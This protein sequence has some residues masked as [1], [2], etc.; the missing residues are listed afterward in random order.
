MFDAV[1]GVEEEEEEYEESDS[2]DVEHLGATALPSC[3]IHR[4]LT[5]TKKKIQ[6]GD[7]DWRRTNIFHTRM[8]HGGRVLNVIIDSGSGMN[9]ISSDAVECLGLTNEKHPG[10]YRVSW[11]NEDNPILVKHRCLVKFALG[12]NYTDEAWC[13]VVPM[14][15]CHLLLGRPWLY[16]RNVLYDGYANSYSFK[17]N[18]KKFVLDPLQ[19]SEFD[20]TKTKEKRGCSNANHLTVYSSSKRRTTSVVGSKPR[21]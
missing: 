21:G 9:V 14:T 1:E 8:E 17:F 4:V 7:S 12:R 3:V 13:D 2:E 20:T 5:G 19:I 16:D 18:G 10:P 11:V 6:G 15:V